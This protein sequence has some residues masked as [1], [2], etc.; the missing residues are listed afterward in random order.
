M[1]SHLSIKNKVQAVAIVGALGFLSYFALSVK[2]SLDYGSL[3]SEISENNLQILNIN[4]DISL[5][6]S[7]VESIAQTSPDSQSLSRSEQ[8]LVEIDDAYARLKSLDPSSKNELNHLQQLS[9]QYGRLLIDLASDKFD[10][11]QEMRELP[12]I[13]SMNRDIAQ[14]GEEYRSRHFKG[15]EDRVKQSQSIAQ[16]TSWFAL[17]VGLSLTIIMLLIARY[18]SNGVTNNL[19]HM[20]KIA[21]QIAQ[22]EWSQPIDCNTGDETAEVLSAIDKMRSALRARS[23]EDEVRESEQRRLVRLGEVS[24]GDVSTVNLCQTI[25]RELTPMLNAQVGALYVA[26]YPEIIEAGIEAGQPFLKLLASYAYVERK[27]MS[28]QFRFG[29]GILGQ[30]A[31]EKNQ[32]LLSNLPADYLSITSSL[33]KSRPSFVVITPLIFN[34]HLYGVFE[35]GF[36]QEPA[37]HD[38]S[39]LMRAGEAIAQSIES[40]QARENV[41]AMLLMTREQASKLAEQQHI[42]Q[43]A[44][45]DLEQQAMALTESEG[46]LMAQQEELRV[47]NEELEEQTKA[48]KLSEERLQA[49]QEELRVTNEELEEHTRA[50]EKQKHDMQLQ[51]EEL[52]RSRKALEEKSS[53]LELSGQYKSEFMSTMSHELRTPLNSI[54][55]LSE[56]LSENDGNHLTEKQVEHA[57]VIHKAGSDLLELINDILD[58]AKVEE[59]KLELIFDE[60]DFKVW[61]KEMRQLFSPIAE[62]KGLEFT[63]QVGEGVEPQFLT[64]S[65]RLNQIIKNLLSNALKF[66]EQGKV[67]LHVELDES[68]KFYDFLVRDTGLGIAPEKQQM[69]FEAFQQTDGAISRKYGGTGLGLTISNRLAKLLGGRISVASEGVGQGSCFTLHLPKELPDSIVSEDVKLELFSQHNSGAS[70]TS[71]YKESALPVIAPRKKKSQSANNTLLIIEDDAIFSETL[72]AIASDYGL[73]VIAADNGKQGL[74]LAISEQPQGIILDLVLPEMAGMDVLKALRENP[75][76]QDIPVHVMSGNDEGEK[77]LSLGAIDFLKKPVSKRQIT[78]ILQKLDEGELKHVLIVESKGTDAFESIKKMLTEQ[79]VQVSSVADVREA[80][81]LVEK[82]TID[83]IIFDLDLPLKGKNKHEEKAQQAIHLLKQA[84]PDT[85]LVVYSGKEIERDFEAKLRRYADRIILKSGASEERLMS[86]VTLFLHWLGARSDAD[87]PAPEVLSRDELFEGK[88]V[89]IVDDDMR[90]VYSLTSGLERRGMEI[91]AAS[92]GLECLAMLEAGARF[93][94]ILMDIMMPEL[95]GF[96]TIERIR[97]NPE[98][99][100]LPI[101]VLTA[102]SLKEDRAKSLELGANDYVLKPLE[103]DRLMALMRVWMT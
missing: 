21:D 77:A 91:E 57:K 84:K 63:V 11:T 59:G 93:D 28:E 29:E 49:Q 1:F 38:L 80:Q 3:F 82:E 22:G 31:L 90:N 67:S 41:N 85:P 44:N 87:K 83:C 103:V 66:T 43:A 47:S 32:V 26:H 53:A 35:L 36:I 18:L 23:L 46:R 99:D 86:E 74:E 102:K 7:Q 58:L 70:N 71:S 92:S 54:L 81:T 39:F 97:Q 75:A 68:G 88:R 69:I 12:K 94:M 60:I 4:N 62:R 101:I 14:F 72:C 100:A 10:K 51:N 17:L 73:D 64:D 95:D 78:D 30:V 40:A 9:R 33:G 98:F 79:S 16:E 76:T 6:L 5:M 50:L 2:N 48:L 56:N 27:G 45:E 8:L 61:E 52:E 89:L 24:R 34:E 25:M 96:S 15:I 19:T 37:T 13:R 20:G 55:I 65:K 42:L